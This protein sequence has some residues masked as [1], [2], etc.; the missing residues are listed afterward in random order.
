MGW[1]NVGS[2]FRGH[3]EGGG[4]ADTTGA[5]TM[6]SYIEGWFITAG[7]MRWYSHAQV[8]TSTGKRTHTNAFADTY[9]A[10]YAE[11]QV[12]KQRTF[13]NSSTHK[14]KNRQHTDICRHVK[15][16]QLD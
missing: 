7:E 8:M 11:K 4:N 5:I 16:L 13:T 10:S 15:L 3:G 6:L 2:G 9:T 1:F 12:D 14:D